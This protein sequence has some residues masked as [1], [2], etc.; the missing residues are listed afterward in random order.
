MAGAPGQPIVRD[1]GDMKDYLVRNRK[2]GRILPIAEV[3]DAWLHRIL[4][5]VTAN[6]RPGS[7]LNPGVSR[8]SYL[9]RLRLEVFIRA[10]GLR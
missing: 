10:A 4:A 1:A 3:P 6:P 9:E 7:G 5:H 2:T 8:E